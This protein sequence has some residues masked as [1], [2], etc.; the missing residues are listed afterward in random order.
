MK[1]YIS[2]GV[3]WAYDSKENTE[4]KS[5]EKILTTSEITSAS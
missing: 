2:V 3:V 1:D 4:K 5:V